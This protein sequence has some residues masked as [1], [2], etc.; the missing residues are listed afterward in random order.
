MV[1]QY[2][3]CSPLMIVCIA[4]P[5]DAAFLGQ[6]EQH[7]QP[8]EQ[9]GLISLWS[10]RHLVPGSS[11]QQEIRQ[12]LEDAGLIL[13]L[14]SADFF[15]SP[16]CMAALE[17]AM[18]R[19]YEHAARVIPVL[20]R[21]VAWQESPLVE[22]S[23]WPPNGLPI[24]QWTNQDAAWHAC[25]QS[26]RRLLGR[27]VSEVLSSQHPRQHAD[28][29][30]ERMLRR[31]RRLY[32]E[33]LDQSLHGLAWMEL[34][35]AAKPEAVNTMANLLFR[36]PQGDEHLLAPGHESSMPMNRLQRNCSS[37][38]LQGPENRPCSSIW[39]SS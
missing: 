34:G 15:A 33:L 11:R 9:A 16:D 30:R 35:L 22:L 26:L 23:S 37:W 12:H 20:L 13:L 7:L 39:R 1:R 3:Q 32:K 31:L 27:R 2:I 14:L 8:L 28:R 18:K 5:E 25:I 36:F 4:A 6:W 24:T 21:P 10:E 38:G 19:A 29:D 17:H